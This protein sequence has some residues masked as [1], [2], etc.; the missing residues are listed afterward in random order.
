MLGIR[1]DRIV[2]GSGGSVRLGWESPFMSKI[3]RIRSTMVYLKDVHNNVRCFQESY[4]DI[5]SQASLQRVRMYT[6]GCLNSVSP[7]K[8]KLTSPKAFYSFTPNP[9]RDLSGHVSIPET[10]L[11]FLFQFCSPRPSIPI[12]NAKARA[13]RPDVALKVTVMAKS[14]MVTL[15]WA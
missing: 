8:L 10:C 1:R 12:F 15:L 4:V 3:Q 2:R 13:E 11:A 14:P 7:F 6:G 9:S 5:S